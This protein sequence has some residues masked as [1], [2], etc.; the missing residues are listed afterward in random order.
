MTESR[1]TGIPKILNA[2]ESNGSPSPI[3]DFDEDY[4]SSWCGFRSIPRQP[5]WW[6]ARTNRV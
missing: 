5:A 2:M 6:F 1:S 3:F 4:S